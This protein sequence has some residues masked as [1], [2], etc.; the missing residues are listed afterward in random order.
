MQEENKNPNS[1]PTISSMM[2]YDVE[3]PNDENTGHNELKTIKQLIKNNG[4]IAEIKALLSKATREE[5]FFEPTILECSMKNNRLDVMQLIMTTDIEYILN[6]HMYSKNI[7]EIA[8]NAPTEMHDLFFNSLAS[9]DDTET[10]VSELFHPTKSYINSK[11]ISIFIDARKLNLAALIIKAEANYLH[12][13]FAFA[14]RS[15][16]N[17]AQAHIAELE[18]E[19]N[20]L[21]TM[22]ELDKKYYNQSSKYSEKSEIPP[23]LEQV[24]IGETDDA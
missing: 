3:I 4:S 20:H 1:E 2:L 15:L 11:L 5:D 21:N 9:L 16:R 23:P 12:N 24:I 17:G 18:K 22:I 10:R 13:E 7:L 8:F 6:K 19:I 14:P